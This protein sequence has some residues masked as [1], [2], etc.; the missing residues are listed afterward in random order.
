LQQLKK[1]GESYHEFNQQ[2]LKVVE[3]TTTSADDASE[4]GFRQEYRE[5]ESGAHFENKYNID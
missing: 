3:E 5:I 1:Q 2:V 4:R